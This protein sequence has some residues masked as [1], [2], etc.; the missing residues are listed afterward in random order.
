VPA[1]VDDRRDRRRAGVGRLTPELL[2]VAP[3]HTP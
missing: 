3:G 1:N 2:D